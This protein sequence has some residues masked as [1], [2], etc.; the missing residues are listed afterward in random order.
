VGT[1]IS[2]GMPF[3]ELV[4]RAG[5]AT[6]ADL[7]PDGTY[8]DA[9]GLRFHFANL[10]PDTVTYAGERTAG[11]VWVRGGIVRGVGPDRSA[12]NALVRVPGQTTLTLG[13][14]PWDAT[15][16]C[17]ASADGSFRHHLP[18]GQYEVFGYARITP[19]RDAKEPFT[20]WVQSTGPAYVTVGPGG[21]V[22]GW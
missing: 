5:Q 1:S 12:S 21:T 17:T 6:P 9:H 2:C 3:S 11:L 22:T 16:Y 10:G 15:D 14:G 7:V 4:T 18:A 19:S 13:S 20:W 8:V